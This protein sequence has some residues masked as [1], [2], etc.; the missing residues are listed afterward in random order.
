[1]GING[2]TCTEIARKK[3]REVR[4]KRELR[5]FFSLLKDLF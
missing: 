1:M 4:A 3:E 2:H 5:F